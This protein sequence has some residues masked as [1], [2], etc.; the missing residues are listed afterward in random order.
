MARRSDEPQ[1][2]GWAVYEKVLSEA[3]AASRAALDRLRDLGEH[4]PTDFPEDLL[5]QVE[6][7]FADPGSE[8]RK[9]LR[10]PAAEADTAVV[11][12]EGS[13]EQ[14]R[15]FVA[16][17]SPGGLALRLDRPL[18]P[19]VILLVRPACLPAPEMLVV[20]VKHCHPEAGEWVA[21]CLVLGDTHLTAPAP[22]A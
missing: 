6:Q 22:L 2:V 11:T 13:E 7:G 10:V 20:E 18:D 9:G 1:R 4:F 8:R 12:L 19:G 3:R 15:A 5:L 21:G 17:R 16:E 14:L